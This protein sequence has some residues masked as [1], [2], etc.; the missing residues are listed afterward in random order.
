MGSR[1]APGW[2]IGALMVPVSVLFAACA[3]PLNSRPDLSESAGLPALSAAA[4]TTL[5]ATPSLQDPMRRSWATVT[6]AVPVRQVNHQPIYR[7]DPALVRQTSRQRGE[8][9]TAEQALRL[10]TDDAGYAVEALVE[11]LS[12]AV[13]L[14]HLPGEWLH[15]HG[16][17][18]TMNSPARAYERLPRLA[19]VALDDGYRLLR[20]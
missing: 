4:A 8:F 5:D 16:P 6:I 18:T 17:W 20:E 19:P 2:R 12:P 3:G 7:A 15:G 14:F 1:R 11:V 10:E 9:P 13:S